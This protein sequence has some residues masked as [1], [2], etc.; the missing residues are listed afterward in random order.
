MSQFQEDFINPSDPQVI[1][2]RL[3]AKYEFYYRQLTM[4]SGGGGMHIDKLEK[5]VLLY[6]ASMRA[7]DRQMREH[8]TVAL[9]KLGGLTRLQSLN[10]RSVHHDSHDLGPIVAKSWQ[11]GLDKKPPPRDIFA[12][13]IHNLITPTEAEELVRISEAIGYRC[14]VRNI[15]ETTT[16][17]S[18]PEPARTHTACTVHSD[19]LALWLWQRI[20]PLV[21]GVSREYASRIWSPSGINPCMRFSRYAEG[22]L[23]ETHIDDIHEKFDRR[24]PE[25]SFFTVVLYLNQGFD[26]GSLRFV[27][28]RVTDRIAAESPERVVHSIAPA[29]G[30]GMVFQHDLLHEACPPTGNIPKYILR[31]DVVFTSSGA[32]M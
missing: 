11:I 27:T 1:E 25:R 7:Y 28:S 29:A 19:E 2:K 24:P 17:R 23:F 30:L 21:C 16:A 6:N 31:T 32:A 3:I 15:P 9:R 10:T 20:G 8:N 18:K 13:K 14:F 12:K 5:E 4:T 26:N 22:Q